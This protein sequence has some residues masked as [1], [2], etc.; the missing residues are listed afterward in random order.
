LLVSYNS[1]AILEICFHPAAARKLLGD[2]AAASLQARHADLQAADNVF[3]LPVGEV[4]VSQNT[5]TLIVRNVLSIVMAPN[6][7]AANDGAVFDWSTVG[8]VKL[9]GVNDVE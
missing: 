5:C 3:Q 4:T 8:R 7:P 1:Q 2:D 6:Y 9:M